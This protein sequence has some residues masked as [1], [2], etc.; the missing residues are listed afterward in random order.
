ME[1]LHKKEFKIGLAV[2][3]VLLATFCVVA[4]YKVISRLPSFASEEV[5]ELKLNGQ[6]KRPAS[7]EKGHDHDSPIHQVSGELASFP[8][9]ANGEP[10]DSVRPALFEEMSDPSR[11]LSSSQVRQASAEIPA[12]EEDS[13]EKPSSPPNRYAMPESPASSLESSAPTSRYPAYNPSADGRYGSSL[14]SSGSPF[15]RPAEGETD[16]PNEELQPFEGT[17]EGE[18]GSRYAMPAQPESSLPATSGRYPQYPSMPEETKPEEEEPSYRSNQVPP[19][20]QTMSSGSTYSSASGFE[21]AI[22]AGAV[23]IGRASENVQEEIAEKTEAPVEEIAEESVEVLSEM[24]PPNTNNPFGDSESLAQE[25]SEPMEETPATLPLEPVSSS[26]RSPQP[27]SPVAGTSLPISP[28]QPSEETSP[29]GPTEFTEEPSQPIVMEEESSTEPETPAESTSPM[30]VESNPPVPTGTPGY[31]ETWEHPSRLTI[32]PEGESPEAVESSEEAP[33]PMSEVATSTE[34]PGRYG[35]GDVQWDQTPSYPS[36]PAAG[37]GNPSEEATDANVGSYPPPQYPSYPMVGSR[38]QPNSLETE[39]ASPE[40]P[41]ESTPVPPM[42]VVVEEPAQPETPAYGQ[43]HEPLPVEETPTP[44]LN[45]NP[46]AT[47]YPSYGQPMPS[48]YEPM[49]SMEVEEVPAKPVPAESSFIAE[50]PSEPMSQPGTISSRQVPEELPPGQPSRVPSSTYPSSMETTNPYGSSPSVVSTEVPPVEVVPAR[51]VPTQPQTPN[52]GQP[53]ASPQASVTQPMAR[54]TPPTSPN[55][56]G[57]RT[58]YVK[59]GDTLFDIA[60]STLGKASRWVEIYDLNHDR[61]GGDFNPLQ[62]GMEL[63][64]P[65][66]DR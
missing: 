6:S 53:P 40:Q 31:G 54:S 9:D 51:E 49:E 3:A 55:P 1:G 65:P 47:T 37:Y 13:Q 4:L 14:P 22:S 48:R 32:Q 62:E 8:K 35:S 58:Y 44:S 63:Q 18:L 27:L 66:S 39:E 15:D 38:P 36:Y 61:L 19:R 50:T 28:E 7:D 45:N 29:M 46:Y 17:A 30:V 57:L 10:K 16:Q 2:I 41:E 33:Q 34:S 23:K 42:E 26:G 21:A 52:Y 43:P 11:L 20:P 24:T 12:E 56:T 5:A 25:E 59:D 64:L 60:R